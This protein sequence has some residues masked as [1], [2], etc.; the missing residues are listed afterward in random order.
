M[1]AKTK[2][3]ILLPIL[4]LVFTI[5]VFILRSRYKPPS[6][7][8]YSP[9]TR[10]QLT[11]S[12]D[13]QLTATKTSSAGIDPQTSLLLTGQAPLDFN[14]ISQSLKISPSVPFKITPKSDKTAEIV[15]SQALEPS[16]I[17]KFVLPALVGKVEAK[18]YNWAFQVSSPLKITG[19]YP[20]NQSTGIPLNAV[21]EIYFNNPDF[22]VDYQKYVTVT[23]GIDGHFEKHQNTLVFVHQGL[24]PTTLYTVTVKS[25]IALSDNSQ[26]TQEDYTFQF[27][28][29]ST[30]KQSEKIYQFTQP[31]FET[32]PSSQSIVFLS[33]YEVTTTSGKGR[34]YQLTADEFKNCL[35]QRST[36]PGWSYYA[37]ARFR[38]Q[39][40]RESAAEFDVDIKST[41]QNGQQYIE[42]PGSLSQPYYLFELDNPQ[43][44]PSQT[45]LQ[46]SNYSWY[47]WFGERES[48]V[49]IN[50]LSSKKPAVSVPVSL[51]GKPIGTTNQ[52]GILTFAT[53]KNFADSPQPILE[54]ATS[55][56][57]SFSLVGYSSRYQPYDFSSYN[58]AHTSYWSYLYTDRNLYLPDDVV[59]LWGIIQSRNGQPVSEVTVNLFP[60]NDYSY[61]KNESEP[62]KS[63]KI[64]VS[65]AGTFV[66]S[67]DLAGVNPGWHTLSVY[68]GSEL[69]SSSGFSVQT[70]T[71]PAFK[72]T[73]KASKYAI[74]AGDSNQIS[75]QA[76]FY[77]GTPLANTTLAWTAWS[78]QRK[79]GEV[80]TDSSG[81][82][83]VNLTTE[84]QEGQ[85]NY[86][87]YQATINFWPKDQQEGDIN[88][89]ASFSVYG[90]DYRLIPAV[91]WDSESSS[92]KGSVKVQ[93]YDYNLLNQKYW[94]ED[95]PPVP[96]VKVNLALTRIWYDQIENGEYYDPINKI[97][98]K[99]YRYERRTEPAGSQELTTDAQ[100]LITFGFSAAK[101]SQYEL[102]FSTKDPSGR[103]AY[104]IS[105][106]FAGLSG[107]GEGES[108]QG[109]TL[110]ADKDQYRVGEVAKIKL[111]ND[112]LPAPSESPNRY[113]LFSVNSGSILD[114]RS[115][116]QN[117]LDFEFQQKY[118]PNVFVK[119]VWFNG[120]NHTQPGYTYGH[121]AG[122]NLRYLHEEKALT[123]KVNSDK[124]KYQPQDEVRLSIEVKDAQGQPRQSRILLSVID[125]ALSDLY[126][127][128]Q[129]ALLSSLYRLLPEGGLLSYSSHQDLESVAKP[130]GGAERGG[131]GGD[132]SSFKNTVLFKEV[133]SDLNGRATLKFK[134]PDNITSWR[135]SS[136]AVSPNLFAG[137]NFTLIPVTKP[138]FVNLVTS[139]NFITSDQPKI[140]AVSYGDS[141]SDSD[142]VKF[143]LTADS[144][145][146]RQSKSA[147]AF[148]TVDFDLGKLS[149]G[150]HKLR[151]EAVRGQESDALIRT[152]NVVDS[153]FVAPQTEFKDILER[154]SPSWASSSPANFILVDKAI[155]YW[156]P[157][158]QQLSSLSNFGQQERLD[159]IAAQSI[160]GELLTDF[161]S[162]SL[163]D[164]SLSLDRYLKSNGY[165]LLPGADADLALTSSIA[166]ANLPTVS[167]SSLK[168]ILWR[169][170]HQES[171]ITRA[172]AALWGLAELNEPVLTIV[173]NLA[174][175]QNSVFGQ[176]Y[177]SL[178]AAALGDHASSQAIFN[179]ATA[180]SLVEESPYKF[181]RIGED[182]T[183]NRKATALAAIVTARLN[184]TEITD[185]FWRYLNSTYDT[186]N[187][188]VLEK[189]L[190]LKHQLA[191]IPS[192]QT[193]FNIYLRGQ[194]SEKTL[195]DGRSLNVE[196]F[197]TEL[198]D[199]SIE[200]RLGRLSLIASYWQKIDPS[201][202]KTD[203]NL[204]I[205]LSLE[206]SNQISASS[207]VK[208]RI[209][210][211]IKQDDTNQSHLATVNLPS[212]LSY[213]DNPYQYHL[214]LPANT[215]YG[216]PSMVKNNQLNF[217]LTKC[218][219]NC[220]TLY[221]LARPVNKGSFTFE[222]S[223]IYAKNTPSSLNLTPS[224]PDLIIK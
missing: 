39:P 201:S 32:T 218:A 138:L 105:H 200:P 90:P 116:S 187:L 163:P 131:G 208:V 37:L 112:Q 191:S 146:L 103:T 179:Q 224:S 124:S 27:E 198:K 40:P 182:S 183:L 88:A 221:F 69:V 101:L 89:F 133:E 67:F 53:P 15:L 161:Y 147:K 18:D 87:P 50:D 61:S 38:C 59:N 85:Q 72:L 129:S 125:Q 102:V 6:V 167:A 20:G 118:V 65:S 34:V 199:F 159:R 98:R 79:T 120:K 47:Y 154:Y 35:S 164:Q 212:G 54:L 143:N 76:S 93:R 126:G 216:W 174:R 30:E 172:S 206:P 207:V 31:I 213:I 127:I 84:Y 42:I 55:P 28:T 1:P 64:P 60:P 104:S 8:R 185:A 222:P 135:L 63:V 16:K 2:N 177:L 44:P 158:V 136:L 25:G 117:T 99:K 115:Q 5:G 157:Y 45:L 13:L 168:T 29:S 33:N 156:F 9:A 171:D 188:I 192:S 184:Q 26:K 97:S 209:D 145:N 83:T 139:D 181:I 150:S 62:L 7:D 81:R 51:D 77:D 70:F 68:N 123:V 22:N 3:L 91:K 215:Y 152:I 108:S 80:T 205:K 196:V 130:A 186:D 151:I 121:D 137:D 203:P 52:D 211:Q 122:L 86:W 78:N 106:F 140:T 82:A 75:I 180:S 94:V 95:F 109:F 92:A 111:L 49:W 162:Q 4:L 195:T 141:L 202:L 107:T 148:Q 194:K 74:R 96:N 24:S 189:A 66:A 119:A 178:A 71:K 10:L 142:D 23:P 128:P 11:S 113:L 43:S 14:A 219:S 149:P 197:P 56:H 58:S 12:Q 57:H 204:D 217:W 170:F 132:R 160:S 173:Q 19:T 166:A 193:V 110:E 17:Y 175:E 153:R 114:H 134:L 190:I 73:A 36:V 223:I 41:G 176:L 155:G 165:S 46:I 169:Y 100:G 220:S 48:L 21:I 210:W 214:D 144:L